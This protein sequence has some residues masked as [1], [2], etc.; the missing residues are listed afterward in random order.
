VSKQNCWER[1]HCGRE[2]TNNN[3]NEYGPCPAAYIEGLNGVHEGINGGR[4][5]WAIAGTF[6][7]GEIQ[8]TFAEKI[9]DCSEC[10]FYKMVLEEERQN[11][12]S[13]YDL[14]QLIQ[15]SSNFF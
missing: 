7:D 13:L 14:R 6:C 4:C 11:L 10:D 12:K 1:K 5:C 9:S 2:Q 15:K 3:D 8:G